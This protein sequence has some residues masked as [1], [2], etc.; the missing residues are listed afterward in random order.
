[1]KRAGGIALVVFLLAASFSLGLLWKRSGDAAKPSVTLG[2]RDRERPQVAI[3]EVR[4]ELSNA[5]YRSI[6]PE[7]LYQP[8][9]ADILEGLE[10]P[11]TDY[12]TASEYEALQNRT[13]RSY[14]GIGLA[15][16][17]SSAGLVVTSA[18]RGP[19]REA[20]IR[21]GDIIT[22]INGRSAA[23]LTF[24][25]SLALIQGEKGTLIRLTVKRARQGRIH[26]SLVRAEIAVPG[27]EARMLR[28]SRTAVG[29]I[30]LL[31]FRAGSAD[32]IS[33][34]TKRLVRRGANGVILDLRDNPGGLLSQA[35]ET[36]SLFLNEGVICTTAG[37][38]RAEQVYTA[39]GTATHP[40][41]PLVVLVNRASASA[42]EIVAAAL[43][44]NGRAVVVGRATYGKASVQS[45]R[46]LS[47]GRALKLTTATY[48]TP[49]GVNLAERG[50]RPRV[51]VFDDPL[52]KRDE[53]IGA[54]RRALLEFI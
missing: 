26:F 36:T 46:T 52:T 4:R 18:F 9:I 17:P 15:V 45:I 35:I 31:A 53:A 3:D 30:R 41:L 24:E 42:A 33:R 32:R 34:A 25:K 7:I 47:N 22:R 1:M 16:E 49:A 21:R 11:Y 43:Q 38:H 27:L 14:G 28:G 29:Y 10:D 37:L 13:D 48:V 8:T 6:D 12:L 5:Y 39:T 54:A 2:L 19:A 51:K 50:V 44:D 23:N 20:G 40:K